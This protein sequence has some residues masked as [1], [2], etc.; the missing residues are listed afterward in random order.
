MSVLL[1]S[2]MAQVGS[3]PV[4]ADVIV[5]SPG[6]ALLPAAIRPVPTQGPALLP[7]AIRPTATS[8]PE[9]VTVSRLGVSLVDATGSGQR[10]G[11]VV[12]RAVCADGTTASFTIPAGASLPVTSSFIR[13]DHETSCTV[14]QVATGGA[15]LVRWSVGT[16]E[17]ERAGTGTSTE[18][19]IWHGNY[20]G[21]NYVVR[22][23][24]SFPPVQ[25]SASPVATPEATSTPSPGASPTAT[26]TPSATPSTSQRP[27]IDPV[28]GKR[29]QVPI[30]PPVVPDALDPTGPTVVL[31]GGVD[32]IAGN[33]V[34]ATLFCTAYTGLLD[35][36]RPMGDVPATCAV[37]TRRGGEV[38]LE[39]NATAPTRVW[40]VFY[41]PGTD[42]FRAYLRVKSW[43]VRP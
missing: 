41:A 15:T 39:M 11:P 9:P 12:I 30:D 5:A 18:V 8:R 23:V 14:G 2:A 36:A 10:S 3:A 27:V 31:P 26:P 16:P 17:G 35:R 29:P 42:K 22:F 1:P 21:H 25:P 28:G 38:T 24:N 43:V 32:T 20:A 40:A 19:G 6:P 4:P 33:R 13:F 7:E 34:R 37:R